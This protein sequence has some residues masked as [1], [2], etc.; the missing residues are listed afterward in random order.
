MDKVKLGDDGNRK[1]WQKTVNVLCHAISISRNA[2]VIL[3]G[4]LLAALLTNTNGDYPF[5][6]TG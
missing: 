6:L 4:A 1:S 2:I 5:Y 3:I